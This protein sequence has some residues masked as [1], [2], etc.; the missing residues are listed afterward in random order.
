[1]TTAY[2]NRIATAVPPHDVHA[3]FVRFARTL[4]SDNRRQSLFQRMVD[5][6]LTNL[7]AAG[8]PTA[9]RS[10]V[11]ASSIMRWNRVVFEKGPL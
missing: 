11:N 9:A 7:R 1:M 4:L 8:F 10:F 3:G 2:L 6:A 5:E